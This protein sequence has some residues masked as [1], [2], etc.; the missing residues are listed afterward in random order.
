MQ[1][2]FNPRAAMKNRK[3]SNQGFSG[4]FLGVQDGGDDDDG[5]G[6]DGGGGG[7]EDGE[8]VQMSRLP[9]GHSLRPSPVN[10]ESTRPTS[11]T[12]SRPTSSTRSSP[13]SGVPTPR[14][15]ASSPYA[16]QQAGYSPTGLPPGIDPAEQQRMYAQYQAQYRA[17]QQ[18]MQQGGYSPAYGQRGGRAVNVA[19]LG[20]QTP[21]RPGPG[22]TTP[23][24]YGRPVSGA[25]YGQPGVPA[26]YVV[27]V[28]QQM[29]RPGSGGYPTQQAQGYQY[30]NVPPSPG[31]AQRPSPRGGYAPVQRGGSP[32]VNS[33]G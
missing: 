24:A 19:P 18:Q 31:Q 11:Q 16:G 5:A 6:G 7:A 17:Q 29:H 9:E 33:D 27:P 4:N 12:S 22:N 10:T 25:A 32:R 30:A 23:Y 8:G 20:A 3:M 13:R 2:N 14:A 28:A 15:P 21:G 26:G 1:R